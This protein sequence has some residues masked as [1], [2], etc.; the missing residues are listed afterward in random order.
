MRLFQKDLEG[1][2]VPEGGRYGRKD[3]SPGC[4]RPEFLA[5]GTP[6]TPVETIAITVVYMSTILEKLLWYTGPDSFLAVIA[7]EAALILPV[8]FASPSLFGYE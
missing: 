1:H 6:A 7:L 5:M 8:W 2:N 3:P 4:H